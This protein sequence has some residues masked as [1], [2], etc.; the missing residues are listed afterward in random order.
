MNGNRKGDAEEIVMRSSLGAFKPKSDACLVPATRRPAEAKPSIET[1]AKRFAPEPP[2]RDE[3]DEAPP[4][5]LTRTNG[6]VSQNGKGRRVRAATVLV[7]AALLP[8]AILIVLLWQGMI[9]F[10][11][12]SKT[13]VQRFP[14]IAL[15]TPD[16]L[17]AKAGEEIGFAIAVDSSDALP[18]RSLIAISGLPDGA[19]FSHGRP[20]GMTGWSLRPDEI[21]EL[22]LRLPEARSGAFDMRIELLAADGTILAQSETRFTVPSLPKEEGAVITVASNPFGEIA[23]Q[24]EAPVPAAAVPAPPE[25]RPTHPVKAEPPVKVSTVKVVTIKPAP[26]AR[27]SHDGAYALSE[28]VEPETEWMEIVSAVDM[29]ARP[30]Q[31]SETVKVI[32]KG[33]KVRVTGRDKNWVQVV[34]TATSTQGWIYKRFLKPAEA[35]KLRVGGRP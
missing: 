32:E 31:T 27:P 8:M 33:V 2:P 28:A 6:K 15:S 1:I 16:R 29:H 4:A 5:K 10:P 3:S 19:L 30:Q 22:R 13:Q 24:V 21:G 35:A 18:A 9:G 17:E 25:R 12:A 11:Q 20:Y 14:E 7:T 34:D 26:A 23:Q